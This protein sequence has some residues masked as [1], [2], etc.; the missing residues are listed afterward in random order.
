[1]ERLL[2]DDRFLACPSRDTI[3]RILGGREL[4][5]KQAD[6][7]ALV[8]LLTEM[9]AGD[10]E[11]A[12]REAARLWTRAQLTEPLGT[13]VGELDPH[14]LEVHRAIDF[15]PTQ[16]D[17]VGPGAAPG[18]PAYVRRG[19]DDRLDDLVDA[20]LEGRSGLAL[21]V[22]TS[23]TGKTRACWE[24]IQRLKSQKWRLWQPLH[25]DRPRAALA[26]LPQ[27]GPRTVVWLNEAHEYLL[28][29]EHGEAVA[30]GLRVLLADERYAPVLVLGTIWPGPGYFD[31]VA[32]EPLQGRPDPH[33]QA[34]LLVAGRALSVRGQFEPELVDALRTSR[35]PRVAEAAH[36]A[37]DGMITQYLAA[38]PELLQLCDMVQPGP[39]ALLTAAMDARRLGHPRGLPLPFLADA[40]EAYLS[41]SEWDLLPDDWCEQAL[42]LL[43]RPVK[44]ARGPLHL[45]KR[46]RGSGQV[47]TTGAGDAGPV[48]QLADFLEQ[49]G[50]SARRHARVPGIFWAAAIRH[51]TADTA[52]VLAEESP[53]GRWLTDSPGGAASTSP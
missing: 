18:L 34:R 48:Y 15:D 10:A 25:P 6:V 28:D 1:M 19:H 37:R 49:H 7:L 40:A 29:P 14:D 20:A 23:S 26:E 30:A 33:G 44:G 38:V 27:V 31:D 53:C 16:S 36:R 52:R 35:D 45:Q 9:T 32:Y 12:S 2:R 21:L 39:K 11:H 8:R 42:S 4:P 43:T 46:A 41:D 13:P 50:R 17:S 47:P 22:G 3:G 5:P 24:A 51:C